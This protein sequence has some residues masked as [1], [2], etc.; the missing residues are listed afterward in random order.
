MHRC[1][2]LWATFRI[3][4]YKCYCAESILRRF[5]SKNNC[6]LTNYTRLW[7]PTSLMCKRLETRHSRR[8]A[9][10]LWAGPRKCCRKVVK[11]NLPTAEWV[12]VTIWH[13]ILF[14]E[15][16]CE[17]LIKSELWWKS[18]AYNNLF[19]NVLEFWKPDWENYLKPVVAVWC[20]YLSGYNVFRFGSY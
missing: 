16:I 8:Y 15:R 1:S 4:N 14:N 12:P 20:G 3:Y 5:L 11:L 10:R 13:T 9:A 17:N 7:I 19:L 2:I 6:V 18:L